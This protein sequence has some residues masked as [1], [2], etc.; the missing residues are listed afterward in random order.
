MSVPVVFR[1]EARTEFDGAADWYEQRQL[2]LGPRFTRA[3]QR[4]LD[5]VARQPD[6]YPIVWR[7][8]REALVRGFPYCVYYREEPRQVLV[9]SVF[10]TARDPA[11]WQGRT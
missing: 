3:V 6:F 8:V 5:R 1:R 9:V 10:H 11:V 4:V 2:G 7:D